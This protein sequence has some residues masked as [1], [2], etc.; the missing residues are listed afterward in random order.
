MSQ[1]LKNWGDN[2]KNPRFQSSSDF[3]DLYI[4]NLKN[5]N[6]KKFQFLRDPICYG[7]QQLPLEKVQ[8]L[9][10][11]ISFHSTHCTS[12]YQEG[13]S[14]YFLGADFIINTSQNHF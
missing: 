8:L 9:E 1:S 13:F 6:F 5:T 11:K 2:I 3:S 4:C 10:E 7:P 12:F 14:A